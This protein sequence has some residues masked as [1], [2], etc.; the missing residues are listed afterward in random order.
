MKDPIAILLESLPQE[1]DGV[2]ITSAVNR[3]YYTGFPSS[4]GTLIASREKSVFIIDSRYAEAAE[5]TIKNCEIVLQDKLYEQI[6]EWLNKLGIKALGIE[7]NSVSIGD[8]QSYR[9]KLPGIEIP[10]NCVVSDAIARQ[11][12]IKTEAEAEAMQAAQTIA[13]KTF[14]FVQELIRPGITEREIALEME[15]YSRKN[16]S[17]GASFSFIIASGPN[18]SMPHA[19]PGDRK[20]QSGDFIT[21]DFGC[22]VNGYCSDMTRTVAVGEITAKQREVYDLV[23][24]AQLDSLA[25]IRPGALCRDVDAVARK[26]IDSSPYK[27]MFGHGLGHSLGLQVH[28]NPR[29]NPQSE[30]VLEAGMVLSVEPGIY[31]PGEFGVRIEDCVLVTEDGYRNLMS[32]PKELIVL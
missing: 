18:S 20:V 23:L 25:A 6:R 21:M 4:A 12:M 30:A 10:M 3:R 15:F 14:A 1:L 27:G 2:M 17:E 28:E 29:F 32:S 9:E 11:R 26:L 24:K 19:V 5:A 8:Y 31:I 7:G 16:G 13:D 22:M